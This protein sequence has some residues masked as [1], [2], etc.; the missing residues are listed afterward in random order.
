MGGEGLDRMKNKGALVY[1]KLKKAYPDA[2]IE[3]NYKTP[4]ELLVATVLSAQCTDV[5]VNQVTKD[6]FR[7]YRKPGDYLARPVSELEEDIRST[8]FF[9]QKT[10]SLR[11]IM[12]SLNA[13]H[14]GKLPSDMAALTKLPGVG[15]KT[16][17]LILGNVFGIPGIVVDTHVGRVSRRLGLTTQKNPDKIEAD[18]SL[19]F[20]RKEWVRLSHVF[21][22]HGRYTCQ[23]KKPLCDS[24]TVATL[25]D[26]HTETM[27]G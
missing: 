13:E 6:L 25:C 10:K 9:R 15:R 27:K 22:F 24:C 16:A 11:G 17:N 12:E 5:R 7:K 2:G 3:L 8:G 19:L 23:A 14:Q 21:L 18:L 26:Y 4:I 20:P 1:R